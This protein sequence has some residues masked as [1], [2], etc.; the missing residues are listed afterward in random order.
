M[1]DDNLPSRITVRKA[2][3]LTR[4][5]QW[6]ISEYE[7][8]R[9]EKNRQD[10]QHKEKMSHLG[11]RYVVVACTALVFTAFV[12]GWVMVTRLDT[13]AQVSIAKSQHSK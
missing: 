8:T 7:K 10:N 1:A 12:V 4:D 6:L 13:N 5:Q 2:D 3:I 11:W 9:L